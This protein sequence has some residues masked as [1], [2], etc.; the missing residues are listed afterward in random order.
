[1]SNS[2]DDPHPGAGSGANHVPKP[3]HPH[4]RRE[5]LPGTVPKPG[6]EDPDAPARLKAI[7]DSDSYREADRD[8]PFLNRDDTR[9]VRLQLDYLKPEYLMAEHGIGHSIVVFGS[10]RIPEPRA[11]QRRVDEIAALCEAAP[12][13][14]ELARRLAVAHRVLDK[15]RYYDVA[16]EFGRLVGQAEGPHGRR[17]AAVN[18]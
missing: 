17:Q 8:P 4:R 16:R 5:A 9:G 10:T 13:N 7:L 12:D 3:A 11:A 1:M 15:S 6:A 14:P 18:A 2:D